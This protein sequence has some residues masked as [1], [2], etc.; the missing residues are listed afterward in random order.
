[1][2][3]S[4]DTPNQ[5][6]YQAF[7]LDETPTGLEAFRPIYPNHIRDLAPELARIAVFVIAIGPG[8]EDRRSPEAKTVAGCE[9]ARWELASREPGAAP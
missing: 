4:A 5:G 9:S 2:N 8:P 7:P 6:V 3:G 1:M